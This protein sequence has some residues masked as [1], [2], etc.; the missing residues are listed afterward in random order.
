MKIRQYFKA[1]PFTV[2]VGKNG[3]KYVAFHSVRKD[4][5]HV[6]I[7]NS[8]TGNVIAF[9]LPVEY[10]CKHDCECYSKKNCYA[11][12]GCYMFLL[13]QASYS[14]NLSYFLNHS[15][16]EFIEEICYQIAKHPSRKLFRWFTCGDI[17]NVR[18]LQA[19][20]EIAR[21]NP[22]IRFWTY[23]KKY[24]IVNSYCATYGLDSIPENLH[25]IFSHWMN[26][27]GSYYPMP[28]PYSFPTSEFIP[29]GKE[30]MLNTV[31]HV[32]PCS[33]PTVH[34]NCCNCSHPCYE[35]K[36]GE[37]MALV[38]HSTER[39][40]TRDKAIK[41]FTGKLFNLVDF[42]KSFVA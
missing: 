13:N 17:V 32:C 8:K 1:H 25:I 19:M 14:E 21:R 22:Q 5:I 7:K 9:N 36:H 10:T 12:G 37:S 42:L 40:K 2:L 29:Y 38:E 4:H 6:S 35:L 18:F 34:E 27:D 33:N 24:M 31:T 39:T 26:D 16:E 28:N 20:V 3:L 23:T 11:C 30:E 15:T 41:A